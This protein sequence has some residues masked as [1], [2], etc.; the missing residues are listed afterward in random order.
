MTPSDSK[1]SISE[2]DHEALLQF[3]DMAPVGLAQLSRD[4]AQEPARRTSVDGAAAP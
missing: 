2:R 3:L 1:P 4:E